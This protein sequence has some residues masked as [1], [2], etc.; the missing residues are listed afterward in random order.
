L[1]IRVYTIGVGS[2]EPFTQMRDMPF[3]GQ[4]PVT[5]RSDMDESLLKA[6]AEAT[7]GQFFRAQNEDSL[8]DIYARIDSLETSE[9][10]AETYLDY[11]DRYLPL[12]LTAL[13]LLLL[14]W[15]LSATLL[16]RL[17]G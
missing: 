8:R 2:K 1:G 4:V 11:H 7:G 13:A 10:E 9:F 6:V 3:I 14:E 15:G 17:P 12:L 16:R 5:V